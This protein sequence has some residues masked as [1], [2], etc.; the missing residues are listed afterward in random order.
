M[1]S[2]GIL[3]KLDAIEKE[4]GSLPR[5]L[6]FY[7]KLIQIQTRV[8]QKIDKPNPGL[9]NETIHQR[10]ADGKALITVGEF[11]FDLHLLQD[12][13]QK[14]AAL[15]GEYADLFDNAPEHPAWLWR[16]VSAEAPAAVRGLERL[17]HD[18]SL[19]TVCQEARCPN[20]A[21]C[22]ARGTATFMILGDTCTRGCRFCAVRHGR[23]APLD[24]GEPGRVAEAAARLHLVHVVVTSVTRDDLPDGGAGH[25]AATID[26]LRRRLPGAALG[27]NTHR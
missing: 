27:Q 16:R 17:L 8:G 22:F 3:D 9:S 2:S 10:M 21:E 15:F 26:A 4:E 19:H 13:F 20:L 25:F 11:T 1:T 18:L 12:T 5:L 7:R 24:P 6:E 23:P 14:I